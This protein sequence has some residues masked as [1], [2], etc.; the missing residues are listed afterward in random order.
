VRLLGNNPLKRHAL[1]SEGI[2]VTEQR[3]LVVGVTR[4]N[5]RYLRAKKRHGH[6]IAAGALCV[7][8]R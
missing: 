6:V 8:R 1:E 5:S 2:I 7:P 4:H 3:P